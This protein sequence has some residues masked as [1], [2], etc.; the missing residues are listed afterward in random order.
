MFSVYRHFFESEE[1]YHLRG[2][3]SNANNH[4]KFLPP[5]DN[6]ATHFIGRHG[7]RAY[8]WDMLIVL[9]HV[10][11]KPDCVEAFREASLENA[12]NSIQEAGIVRFDVLQDNEDPTRFILNEV[13]RD[14]AAPAA[15][16]ETAHYAAWRD[17][18]ADMMAKPRHAVKLTNHFPADSEW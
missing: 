1:T 4:A 7:S 9:V 3:K 16:K 18:V 11:V 6:G 2:K 10:H 5:P 14:N 15:H 12:R 13:Y 8:R 17:T